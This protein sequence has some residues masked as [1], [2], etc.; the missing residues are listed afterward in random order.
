MFKNSQLDQNQFI[1]Q[2]QERTI[3]LD[4]SPEEKAANAEY[5]REKTAKIREEKFKIKLKR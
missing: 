2:I 4:R 5:L 1:E 3:A